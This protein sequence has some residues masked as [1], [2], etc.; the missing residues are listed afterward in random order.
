MTTMDSFLAEHY[1]NNKT[2]AA[3][4]LEK[5]ASVD[6]FL[7]LAEEQHIDLKSMPDAKVTELYNSWQAVK[8][9]EKEPGKD[10]AEKKVEEEARKEHAEKK[11]NAEKIAEADYLGRVMAHAY[12]NEL[13]KIAAD[14][15]TAAPTAAKLAEMPE[16]LRKG[17]E[18]ARGGKP[19][20]GKGKDEKKDD[21]KDEKEAA[22][23]VK[24]ASAIDQLAATHAVRL[25]H[26]AG[27]SAEE[28]GRKVAAVLELGLLGESS[29]VASAPD[30]ET[31]THIRA[32]ELLEKAGYQVTWS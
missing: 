31:A 7:K 28:A 1:G 2:A 4:D 27:L 32:L 23:R 29:K 3:E 10:E 9:A 8:A 14:T 17:M 20:E 16:A 18:A 12:T 25:A 15:T 5:D 19:E 22:A 30:V 11:A 13:R 26:D 24:R 21:K 6:L